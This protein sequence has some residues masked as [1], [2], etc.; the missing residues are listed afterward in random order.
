MKLAVSL[1]SAATIKQGC[2][3]STFSSQRHGM[4][5][6]HWP[7]SLAVTYDA[8]R[9]CS[10]PPPPRGLPGRKLWRHSVVLEGHIINT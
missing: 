10:R 4:L 9:S 3:S 7:P 6:S 2:K 5:A 1:D 8:D